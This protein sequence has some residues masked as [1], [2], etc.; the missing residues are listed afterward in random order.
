MLKACV[1]GKLAKVVAVAGPTCSKK[2][3]VAIDM[4]KR[5]NGEVISCDAMA[6]YR[7]FNVG[8]ETPSSLQRDGVAHHMINCV[9]PNEEVSSGYWAREARLA[10][11]DCVSR[12]KTPIIAGG[13]VFYLKR[14]L[15]NEAS[16][17]FEWAP[18]TNEDMHRKLF[19]E[20]SAK[21]TWEDAVQLLADVDPQGVERLERNNYRRLVRYLEIVRATGKSVSQFGDWTRGGGDAGGE[22]KY[23]GSHGSMGRDDCYDFRCVTLQWRDRVQQFT[24]IDQRCERILSAGL[25]DETTDLARFCPPIVDGRGGPWLGIGYKQL[26]LLMVDYC[27]Q[28]DSLTLQSAL[29]LFHQYIDVFQQSSRRLAR[30]QIKWLRATGFHRLDVGVTPYGDLLDAVQHLYDLE[31]EQFLATF[32]DDKYQWDRQLGRDEYVRLRA[33]QSERV[34]YTSDDSVLVHVDALLSYLGGI[35][36]QQFLEDFSHFRFPS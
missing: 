7:G 5:L 23:G 8:T 1:G 2:T 17:D 13:S 33:Y 12:G 30:M 21:P 4:A 32:D 31:P 14:L 9:E 22:D 19:A 16:C 20:V 15:M 36:R 29:R 27:S 35:D 18:P 24:A 25:V 28:W 6:V 3:E 10:I 26:A 11:E 34:I